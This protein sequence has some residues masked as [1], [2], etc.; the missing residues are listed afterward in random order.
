MIA[1]IK[2]A[3][4]LQS[5]NPELLN[6]WRWAFLSR[7]GTG[8]RHWL[9]FDPL[10]VKGS[11]SRLGRGLFLIPHFFQNIAPDASSTRLHEDTRMNLSSL[12]IKEIKKN[13]YECLFPMEEETLLLLARHQS[14]ISKFTY[15]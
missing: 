12:F 2:V 1:L 6:S 8:E 11:T 14:E 13:H 10:V 3:V 9:C 4:I 15:C 7:M 5:W